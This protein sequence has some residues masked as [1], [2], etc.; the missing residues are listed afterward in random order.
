MAITYNWQN[1]RQLLL[2][3]FTDEELRNFCF[4]S[5]DF[6]AVYDQLSQQAGKAQIID[7]LLDHAYRKKLTEALLVWAKEH[8]PSQF[9]ENQPYQ[10]PV[11]I[12]KGDLIGATLGG[13]VESQPAEPPAGQPLPAPPPPEMP[14]KAENQLAG[15]PPAPAI[16]APL[17][18]T[19]GVI[20]ALP[21]EYVAVKTLLENQREMIMPGQGAGRRYLLGQIPAAGGGKHTVAL[22]LADMGNNIAAARATLLLEHFSTVKSIIMVGIAGGVPHPQKPADHVRLGDVVVSNQ[23]GV[24]QYDFD[25]ETITGITYRIPPRPPSASLLEGVRLLE[26]AEI[27]GQR[28]WLK[29]LD[30]VKPTRPPAASD[31][32]YS[33]TDPALPI[34]H[35]VDSQREPGR[36][37]IFTG[38]IASANKLLKNPLKR[39]ELRDRFRVKAVEMEGSGIA[40]AA[41]QHEVGYLVVRGICDYCDIHKG[42]DWQVYAAAAAAAYTRA[43]I[44][45]I[46][47]QPTKPDTSKRIWGI[48]A[49]ILPILLFMGVILL[50]F[51]LDPASVK[52]I[53]RPPDGLLNAIAPPL[54]MP[55]GFNIAVA[56]FSVTGQAAED[57]PAKTGWEVSDWLARG[58]EADRALHPDIMVNELWGPDEMGVIPGENREDRAAHAERL[59]D[60]YHINILIYG[61]ITGH[62]N[63]YFVEPEFFVAWEGF[64]YASEVAGPDQLGRQVPIQLPF[65]DPDK[66]NLNNELKARRRVLQHVVYGLGYFYY[67]NDN[68]QNYIEAFEEFEDAAN[69]P[70]GNLEVV[71][72]LKG[73]A[74]LLNADDLKADP[75]QR[76]QTLNVAAEAFYRAYQLNPDYARSYLGLGAVAL[77][78]ATTYNPA[79]TDIIAADNTRLLEARDW[80]LASLRAGDQPELAY[81]PFKAVH[82]L[83]QTHFVGY[84]YGFGWSKAAA[85]SYLN[86][87]INQ[88]DD[89]GRPPEVAW[90]AGDAHSLLCWLNYF[91]GL[92]AET[93]QECRQA[94][95]ILG[96]LKPDSA[97][98]HR[99]IALDWLWVAC[100]QK[101][102]KNFD[103]ARQA[104]DQAINIGQ[105]YVSAETLA[106]W[107]AARDRV[108]EGDSCRA[109]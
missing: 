10:Q 24:I 109:N 81:V 36:P 1:I 5:R 61:V 72:L 25:Q 52:A 78:Q 27:E 68:N 108:E 21:K 38:P 40:D 26:A 95:D 103:Q 67:T 69:E 104:Y 41:W 15:Q 7:R 13:K 65:E 87:V 83:G 88:Y 96:N 6:R 3:G 48:L 100:A 93:S 92:W 51:A 56:E 47:A 75:A 79:G 98:I 101:K 30:R 85:R 58:I 32:L 97:R 62:Q 20:T 105:R 37:R 55:G 90:F 63:N 19:I 2:E 99:A 53:R 22:S 91:D 57:F 74:K 94:I 31:I 17:K 14:E 34:P 77:Q 35:P 43:L 64:D 89:L 8:N 42:D 106:G 4:D 86:L 82:G 60:K 46:P 33:S 66:N 45:S 44:E 50:W 59:A 49:G 29:Y 11:E 84:G 16:P 102:L 70:A 73:A 12:K 71:Y 18:P 39:D 28:P 76:A 23:G 9:E 107:Q 80:Y 54:P